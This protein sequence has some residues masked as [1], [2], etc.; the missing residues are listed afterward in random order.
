MITHTRTSLVAQTVKHLPTL[1]VT[2]VQSLGWGYLLE[3]EMATHSRILSWKIPWTEEPGRLQSMRL[4]KVGHDLATSLSLAQEIDLTRSLICFWGNC[5]TKLTIS[6]DCLYLPSNPHPFLPV[7]N[8][9]KVGYK[10]CES[11][12]RVIHFTAYLRYGCRGQWH[13]RSSWDLK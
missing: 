5:S 10:S 11:P 4:Q 3:K 8:Q 6:C 7:S 12:G 1:W 13:S 9:G 2:R